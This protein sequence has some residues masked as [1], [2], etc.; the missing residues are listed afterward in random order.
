[1]SLHDIKIEGGRYNDQKTTNQQICTSCKLNEIDEE[2][3]L[4]HCNDV[5]NEHQL[6]FNSIATNGICLKMYD[7]Y[8]QIS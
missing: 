2:I 5:N 3:L 6:I 4:L 8:K 1:M 7:C